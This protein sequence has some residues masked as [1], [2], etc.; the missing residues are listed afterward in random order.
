MEE[1]TVRQNLMTQQGYSPYCGNDISRLE[2]GGCD[3]PRTKFN[4]KQ[5]ICPRC[6]WISEF[7]SDFIER[8]K[9]KWAENLEA[10]KKR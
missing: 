2:V 10:I 3:N 5:F 4:G 7:P 1:T 8:Y 6:S 9:L